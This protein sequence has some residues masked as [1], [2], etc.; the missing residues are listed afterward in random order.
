MGAGLGMISF[1]MEAACEALS[2]GWTREV[3]MCKWDSLPAETKRVMSMLLILEEPISEPCMCA[4][5]MNAA[6]W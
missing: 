5:A 6:K 4:L 3:P 2:A 1:S